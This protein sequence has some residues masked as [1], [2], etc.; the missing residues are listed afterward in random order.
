MPAP[1]TEVS[2]ILHGKEIF[3]AVLQPGEYIIGRDEVAPIRLISNKVSRQHAKLTLRDNDWRLEDL[4]G[5]NG[6][7]IGGVALK[8][9]SA[10]FPRQ[11]IAIGDVHLRLHCTTPLEDNMRTKLAHIHAL[12]TLLPGDTRGAGR[13]H[14]RRVL[15]GGGMG[16]VVQAVDQVMR[17]HVAMKILSQLHP[18]QYV[19]RF[20]EEVQ[21]IAQLD[22][23]GIVPIYDFGV[24]EQG[25]PFYTMPL[26]RGQSL[27]EILHALRDAKESAVRAWTLDGLVRVLLRVCDALA[28]AHSRGVVHRDIKPDNIMV[29][30]YGEVLLLDWG[31]AKVLPVADYDNP[32]GQTWRRTRGPVR[33]ARQEMAG[34]WLTTAGVALG[35]PYFMAPEQAEGKSHEV[36]RRT[37]IYALGGLLY[38]LLTLRPPAAGGD[39]GGGVIRPIEDVI[40]HARPPHLPAGRLPSGVVA[41][42][43]KALARNPRDR[44]ADAG[45]FRSAVERG[46]GRI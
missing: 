2:A 28:F 34:E 16:V 39:R 24:N 14:L 31:L 45:A 1:R 19:A 25:K 23:P 4:G 33:S 6:T 7:T 13:Y 46:M 42:A 11:E 44:F 12:E 10:V 32:K 29:G 41:A 27:R 3:R 35:T 21:I 43:M 5:V 30:D 18:P 15:G 20:V 38:M 8:G 17:R 9:A 26:I 36:D 40:N 37:D 22:H